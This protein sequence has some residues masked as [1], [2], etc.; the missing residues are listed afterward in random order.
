MLNLKKALTL[1]YAAIVIPFD[2]SGWNILKYS[3]LP[4]N[5]VTQGKQLTIQVN[6]SANPIFYIFDA[7]KKLN[8]LS[9][10]GKLS[11]QRFAPNQLLD[12]DDFYLR[13][14]IITE[15]KNKLGFFQKMVASDW[16][17]VLFSK[18]EKT[19]AKG[20]GTVQFFAI[21]DSSLINKEFEKE[22]FDI[23][24]STKFV[25]VVSKDN[26]FQINQSFKD[27][28]KVVGLWINSD[29]DG[30]K[31]KFDVIIDELKVDIE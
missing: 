22:Y 9:V 15:G 19:N 4:P 23:S 13:V 12:K 6:K 25:S 18:A 27:G 20:I 24:F 8:T 30:A 17:K 16:L 31:A 28:Q 29:G 10:K 2:S 26:T 1:S 21:G 5:K 11:T 14:G 7:P 3:N